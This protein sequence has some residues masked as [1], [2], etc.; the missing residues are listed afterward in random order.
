MP[1]R[2]FS[3]S[4]PGRTRTCDPRFRKPVLYPTE[5][6]ALEFDKPLHINDLRVLCRRRALGIRRVRPRCARCIRCLADRRDRSHRPKVAEA[7]VGVRLGY[8]QIDN[9]W[10]RSRC[11]SP[12][13]KL[14]GD[15]PPQIIRSVLGGRYGD[16]AGHGSKDSHSVAARAR[17]RFTSTVDPA[18]CRKTAAQNRPAFRLR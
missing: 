7:L 17:N 16:G 8:A 10:P 6:R 14:L 5:L 9:S 18:Q 3:G 1:L 13:L 12:A 4:A 2:A 15:R 11:P